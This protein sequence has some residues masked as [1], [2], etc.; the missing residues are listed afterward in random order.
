M[1]NRFS[2]QENWFGHE[3][4][5]KIN[6]S[7]VIVVGLGGNGSHVVQQL[8]Y[9]GVGK[10]IAVDYQYLENSNKNRLVGSE[11]QDRK[12]L[13]TEI[14]KRLVNRIDPTIDFYAIENKFDEK[15]IDNV[16]NE[17]G[18][19]FGCVDNDAIR[20]KLLHYSTKMNLNYIDLASDIITDNDPIIYGGRVCVTYDSKSCIFCLNLLSQENI[21]R[22]S[23]DSFELED[24]C[25]IYGI[26]RKLLN[27]AGP[28]VVTINGVIAS[29]G[30][31]E[32]MLAVTGI[33]NPYRYLEYRAD[34]GVVYKE[35]EETGKNCIYC[36]M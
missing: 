17:C 10:I 7:N 34:E 9:L 25:N 19:I 26:N 33:R 29:L 8:S 2:R 13:K 5:K 12:I 27:E 23:M 20:L 30:T 36:N 31:T 21:R 1:N 15:L 14:S 16:I 4:Q 24:E 18:W 22:Y 11:Y 35:I 32:F 28:S 3:G 6:D